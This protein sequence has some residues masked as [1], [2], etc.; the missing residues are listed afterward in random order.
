MDSGK[1]WRRLVW[2]A[3]FGDLV[4][5]VDLYSLEFGHALSVEK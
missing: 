3:K 4:N 1:F 2:L 5:I